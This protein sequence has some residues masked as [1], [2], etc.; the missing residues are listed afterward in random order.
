MC[1]TVFI[2]QP[3]RPASMTDLPVPVRFG[4]PLDH[5]HIITSHP[6]GNGE[7]YLRHYSAVSVDVGTTHPQIHEYVA[8]CY[9]DPFGEETGPLRTMDVPFTMEGQLDPQCPNGEIVDV[10]MDEEETIGPFAWYEPAEDEELGGVDHEP[11]VEDPVVEPMEVDEAEPMDTEESE[12]ETPSEDS[13]IP[14]SSS[15]SDGSD[16]EWV[17]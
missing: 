9:L 8:W 12:E 15:E 1:L 6:V 11:V 13:E 3:F 10:E 2:T 16:P 17:P 7:V 14:D 4:I 5:E